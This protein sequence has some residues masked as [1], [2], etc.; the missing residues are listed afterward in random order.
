M[1]NRQSRT[2]GDWLRWLEYRV[3]PGHRNHVFKPASV[4]LSTNRWSQHPACQRCVYKPLRNCHHRQRV[5]TLPGVR[6]K[7]SG[8][9]PA[10]AARHSQSARIHTDSPRKTTFF[11]VQVFWASPL[12]FGFDLDSMLNAKAVDWLKSRLNPKVKNAGWGGWTQ[13][14]K[15]PQKGF[16]DNFG[17]TYRNRMKKTQ[18]EPAQP[19]F[20]EL[21][22]AG[23]TLLFHKFVIELG[24]P[25]YLSK[26]NASNLLNIPNSHIW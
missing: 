10:A 21:S 3:I 15:P 7:R 25:D 24:Q 14:W 16:W 17:P 11:H 22:W 6:S 9:S 26:V 1:C 4:F 18:D 2:A 23:S 12:A 13:Q 8:F 5:S 19:E 20:W